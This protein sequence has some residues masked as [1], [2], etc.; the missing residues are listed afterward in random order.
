MNLE[1]QIRAELA[2]QGLLKEQI[3]E[4]IAEMDLDE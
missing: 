2:E 3:D 1:A 4:I